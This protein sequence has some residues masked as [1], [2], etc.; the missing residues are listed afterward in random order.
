MGYWESTEEYPDNRPDIWNPSYYCWTGSAAQ[1][2]SGEGSGYYDLCGKKI[3][4]HKFP[5]TFLNNNNTTDVVHFRPDS[6]DYN[7]QYFIR[8]MGAI[9]ENI[10]LPKDQKGNDIPGIVGYEILRGSREGNKTILAKG[11]VNNLRSYELRGTLKDNFVGLYPNYPFNTIKPIGASTNSNDHNYLYNDPYIKTEAENDDVVNQDI[12]TDIFTFHSPDTMFRI[13]YLSTTEFK[14]YGTLNGYADLNF[15][16]PNGH[17]KHILLSDIAATLMVLAGVAEAIVSAIGKRNINQP[18]ILPA[19]TGSDSTGAI[20]AASLAGIAALSGAATIYN[21]GILG[22]Y[23]GGL[24]LVDA[25]T[26]IYG[27]YPATIVGLADAA[28]INAIATAA[29][30]ALHC[31]CS[32]T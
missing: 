18:T 14:L 29:L 32:Q 7:G 5:E 22:Y 2:S 4:H 24:P 16:E 15:Q 1:V 11:M 25:F 3:R 21:N 13:P 26:S 6:A 31:P 17:P 19:S 23:G 9:F 27:G 8:L 20:A 30:T 28:L 10:T 12:P